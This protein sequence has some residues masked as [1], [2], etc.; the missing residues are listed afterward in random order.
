MYNI[1]TCASE[2]RLY[3]GVYDM[4]N[5]DFDLV[6]WNVSSWTFQNIINMY[7]EIFMKVN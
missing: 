2:Y 7:L 6:N 5:Q 3:V 4:C 1:Y